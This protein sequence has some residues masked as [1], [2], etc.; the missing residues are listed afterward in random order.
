VFRLLLYHLG[1]G[2]SIEKIPKKKKKIPR[3][4]PLTSHPRSCILPA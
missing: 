1:L 3:S 4:T 2:V